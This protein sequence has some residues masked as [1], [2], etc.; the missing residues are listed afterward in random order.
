MILGM[1]KWN[2][3]GDALTI[4]PRERRSPTRWL[5]QNGL[6][7]AVVLGLAEAVFAWINGFKVEMTLIGVVAVLLYLNVRHHIPQAVRRPLWVIV[8]AQ[9]IA[10]LVLPLIYVG[11]FMFALV[12]G[13]LLVVLVLVMLGDRMRK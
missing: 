8:M 6:R 1:S 4:E 9:G 13:L 2:V 7:I 10:G 12:G 3:S 5:S 11:L